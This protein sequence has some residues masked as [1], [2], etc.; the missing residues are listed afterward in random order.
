MNFADEKKGESKTVAIHPRMSNGHAPRAAN[1]QCCQLQPWLV[2][3]S[4]QTPQAPARITLLLPHTEQVMSMN[5]L[6]SASCTR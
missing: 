6:P 4:V 5:M 1:V 2:P 3:H